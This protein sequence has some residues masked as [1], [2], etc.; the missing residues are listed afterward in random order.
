MKKIV[1]LILALVIGI[2]PIVSLAETNVG[3]L[4]VTRY[5]NTG[6]TGKLNVRTGP[7]TNADNLITRLENGT[8]VT[9]VGYYEG[10]TW[11]H[12]S[13]QLNGKTTDGYVQTRY[14]TDTEPVVVTKKVEQKIDFSKF[15]HVN[16]YYAYVKPSTPGGFV[17]M[18][19]APSKSNDVMTKL[20]A[21]AEVMVIARNNTWSQIYD[22]ATGYVGFI[23]NSFLRF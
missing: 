3:V 20:Y 2:L 21:D 23:M 9:V 1:A 14:L 17:N 4:N 16:A 7:A 18:R 8:K 13:F 12:I 6:N 15:Q 10:T 5:V 19:W 11:A 22:P